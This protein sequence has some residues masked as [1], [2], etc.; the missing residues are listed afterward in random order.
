MTRLVALALASLMLTASGAAAQPLCSDGFKTWSSTA[1][2]ST[3]TL[4]GSPG[5]LVKVRFELR[6]AD[7]GNGIRIPYTQGGEGA[8]VGTLNPRTIPPLGLLLPGGSRLDV[9]VGQ[10]GRGGGGGGGTALVLD[11]SEL[12]ALAAGG[13]GA[14]PT[15]GGS[16]GKGFIASGPPSQPPYYGLGY[17]FTYEDSAE[18]GFTSVSGAGFPQGGFPRVQYAIPGFGG[19]PIGPTMLLPGSGGGYTLEFLDSSSYATGSRPRDAALLAM[20]GQSGMGQ[21]RAG[22]ASITCEGF[23]PAPTEPGMS[24]AQVVT[25]TA[26]TDD[27]TCDADCSLREAIAKT[28]WDGTVTFAAGLSGQTLTVTSPLVTERPVTIDASALAGGISVSGGNATRVFEATAGTLTL[29]GLTVRDGAADRGAGLFVHD[30]TSAVAEG[31]R[32]TANTATGDGGGVY[33]DGDTFTARQSSFDGNAAQRGAGLYVRTRDGSVAEAARFTANT[34]TGDGG[35]VYV[36]GGTFSASRSSFDGNAASNG[37]AVYAYGATATLTT[38]SVVGNVASQRAAVLGQSNGYTR[39]TVTLVGSTVVG[40]TASGD[41]SGVGAA[42]INGTLSLVSTVI[43]SAATAADCRVD[44]PSGALPV[45]TSYAHVEDGTCGAASTGDPVLVSRTGGPLGAPVWGPTL[46]SPLLDAGTCADGAAVDFRGVGRPFDAPGHD[47]VAD[48]CDIGAVEFSTDDLG[49]VDTA[50]VTTTADTDDGVCDADCSLREA[51]GLNVVRV[52][53]TITFAAELDGQT[54]TV[55]SPLVPPRSVTIDASALPNGLSV[56]GGNAVRVFEAASGTLTLRSLAVRDGA[57]EDGAGLYV[58]NGAAAVA[59]D[60]RFTANTATRDGGAVYAEGAT[61]TA[62]QSSFDANIAKWGAAVYSN[63]SAVTLTSSSVVGNAASERAAVLGQVGFNAAEG[64]TSAVRLEGSTVAGNTSGGTGASGVWSLGSGTT[65]ALV[66]TVV[67]SASTDPDCES[68][69]G[70]SVS[71]SYDHIEDGTCGATSEGDPVL[72]SRGATGPLGAP[73]WGPGVKSP[74]L[75][76]GTCAVDGAADL[77]ADLRG[78]ARPVDNPDVSNAADGCDVGAVEAT[79]DE[80]PSILVASVTLDGAA[81]WRM[82]SA[83]Q[84]TTMASFLA[85]FWTQGF[86]GSDLPEGDCTVFTFDEHSASFA[87]GWTCLADGEATTPAGVGVMVYVFEDDDPRASAPGVQNPFPKTLASTAPIAPGYFDFLVRF[88]DDERPFD[89]KGWNLLGNPSGASLSWPR[90]GRSGVR[91][92][93]YVYDPDYNGG[94]YRTATVDGGVTYGDLTD[95]EI[96]PFQGFFVHGLRPEGSLTAGDEDYEPGRDIYGR[97]AAATVVRVALSDDTGERS[98]AFLALTEAGTLGLDDADAARLAPLAWPRAV[99]YTTAL[100]GDAPLVANVLPADLGGEPAVE[101]P[102]GIDA[103]GFGSEVALSLSATAEVLPDGWHLTL[104]D[105][106]TG[107]EHDLTGGAAYAFTADG[108][109]TAR[110]ASAARP[111]AL[112]SGEARFALRIASARATATGGGTAAVTALGAIAPN[113]TAGRA[114]VSWTLAEAGPA[115]VAVVDL[116]GR[117]VA[118]L[119]DGAFAAGPQRAEVPAGLAPGVYVVRLQAGATA[120]AARFTIVR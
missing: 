75:D 87:E 116:L 54:L 51:L 100:G 55:A 40:N 86:P 47:A 89:Q 68:G 102:L 73:V 21:E 96:P 82:L 9:Y 17:S 1:Q 81:G 98:S 65:V 59:E 34:A 49:S 25:T 27:G 11:R 3:L 6:G 45:S 8:T 38:S 19:T 120:A 14:W 53:G 114:T 50:V 26:D 46:A 90:M 70:G 24:D 103:A 115:R 52:G 33:A 4:T 60:V 31:V 29:R 104:V 78:Q 94:D 110:S 67:A 58:R 99:V 13:G 119:A 5:D 105:R 44:E 101:V 88:E 20:P 2:T 36:E 61:F 32:F 57:A 108:G 106:Q 84:D 7:G 22:S 77:T 41:I 93:V 63:G 107:A 91:S 56:S 79:M 64:K 83:P 85:G 23:I 72:V 109:G 111:Q 15:S 113:P 76:A 10:P 112:A 66:S 30:G 42:G 12:I 95:G 69:G 16:G 28:T 92:T 39:S 74:L 118:V 71:L 18:P 48:G 80:V 37:A 43:A 97:R 62:R 35:G 117:E